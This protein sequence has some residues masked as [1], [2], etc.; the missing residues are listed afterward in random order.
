MAI[1]KFTI[2]EE[3]KEDKDLVLKLNLEAKRI[4]EPETEGPVRMC[5]ME[6]T[7]D[8]EGNGTPIEVAGVL[9]T[10]LTRIFDK[11]DILKCLMATAK[12]ASG[13]GGL[14]ISED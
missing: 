13:R 7:L 5:G 2:K 8:A 10:T 14:V 3:K 1:K 12:L 4:M 9:Y 6:C 11:E